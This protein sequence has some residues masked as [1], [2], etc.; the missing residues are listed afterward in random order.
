MPASQ[1]ER[2]LFL[3]RELGDFGLL[4]PRFGVHGY[5]E[6]EPFAV[7]GFDALAVPVAHYG[8]PT[9]GL[10][11]QHGGAA[12]ALSADTGPT[13]A[14]ARLA[15]DADLFVCEATLADGADEGALRGHLSAA[16][17]L[18]AHRA[19]GA[20]RLLLTHRPTELPA[21]AGVEVARP[22]LVV[23]L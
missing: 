18:E 19:A 8:M 4:D 13:P 16:E 14:L 12:L 7:A 5:P 9:Y 3:A 17:A 1:R 11:L 2:F 22:G 23:E 15:R 21:P 10:R 6:D 20:R